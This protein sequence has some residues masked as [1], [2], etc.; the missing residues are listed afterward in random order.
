MSLFAGHPKGDAS[1]VPDS[2]KSIGRGTRESTWVLSGEHWVGCTYRGTAA[3]LVQRVP[4]QLDRCRMLYRPNRDY[5]AVSK[6][7][8][9]S[10][11]N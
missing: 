8:C 10:R 5:T 1:L 2:D 3:M 9:S 6:F 7:V 11:T 4:A